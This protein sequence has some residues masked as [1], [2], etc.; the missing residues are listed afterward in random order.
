[1]DNLSDNQKQKFSKVLD[2]LGLDKN[3]LAIYLF[4]LQD[5]LEAN[6]KAVEEYLNYVKTARAEIEKLK[7]VSG[8]DY[9]SYAQVTNLVR[10]LVDQI[11][12]IDEPALAQRLKKEIQAGIRIPKDGT[13][14]Q[15]AVV[16]YGK[17]FDTVL[18]AIPVPKDGV[19]GSPDTPVEVRNKLESLKGEDRLDVSAIQ[20][21]DKYS[22][23][24]ENRAIEILDK[25]SQFLINKPVYTKSEIDTIL[26][27]YIIGDGVH[28]ITVGTS[29]PTNPQVGDLWCDTT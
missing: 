5:K 15:N 17:I 3:Q 9:P 8:M 29:Q 26:G 16:D 24:V 22:K 28:K 2:I 25:R 20:G 14:G 6:R 4:D 23:G 10:S 18:A 19:N 11:P 7:P 1:M 13:P 12:K 27:N 21:L